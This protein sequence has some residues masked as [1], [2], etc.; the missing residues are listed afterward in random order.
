MSKMWRDPKPKKEQPKP[1]PVVKDTAPVD[2]TRKEELKAALDA[3]R[4]WV[5]DN[6]RTS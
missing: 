1:K 5:R 4:Q 2:V 3:L 6:G